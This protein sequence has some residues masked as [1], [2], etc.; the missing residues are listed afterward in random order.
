MD[1]LEVIKTRFSVRRYT[2]APVEQ[3]KLNTILEAARLAPTACN[4]QPFKVVVIRTA[5]H[6]E[7]LKAIYPRSFFTAA[8]YV[9]G[10]FTSP[11]DAWSR[12]DNKNYADVDASIVMDHIIL[13][14]ASIGLGTCWIGAFD[15]DKARE[16]AG[17][18]PDWEPLA[19]T[20]VGYPDKEPPVKN[21]R[22]LDDLV[23]YL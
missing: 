10:V 20:P 19:F 8:P 6:Q 7:A 3:E 1:C 11:S 16:F 23:V 22:P 13:A 9:L 21:R 14:A 12:M 4:L 2:D 18:G 17:L 15:P 5:D